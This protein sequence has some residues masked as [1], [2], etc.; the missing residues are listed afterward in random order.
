VLL[1]TAHDPVVGTLGELAERLWSQTRHQGE[2][3]MDG[4]GIRPGETTS[5]VL[6]G[7][8]EE[9]GHERHQGIAEIVG[10]IPTAAPAWVLERLPARGPREDA[11]GVWMEA[12]RRPGLI[13]PHITTSTQ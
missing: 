5:E 10:E 12:M 2:P 7:P 11:R 6:I 9:M 8:G 1:A 13:A 4:I 3:E